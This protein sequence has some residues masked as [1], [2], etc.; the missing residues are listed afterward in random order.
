MDVIIDMR[1]GIYYCNILNQII[2][3]LSTNNYVFI[4]DDGETEDGKWGD[5]RQL[6]DYFV[7]IGGY[8]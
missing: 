8:K 4:F 2:L 6:K 5:I 7:Y 1:N 3:V